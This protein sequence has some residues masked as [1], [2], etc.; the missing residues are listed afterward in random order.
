M[1]VAFPVP[2]HLISTLLQQGGL[3]AIT[4]A[5]LLQQFLVGVPRFLFGN[6]VKRNFHKKMSSGVR[7]CRLVSSHVVAARKG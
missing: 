4:R 1:K 7:S 6:S 5:Q 2:R 3:G